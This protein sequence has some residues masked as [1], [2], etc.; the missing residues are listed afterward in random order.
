[1][2]EKVKCIPYVTNILHI[3]AVKI[4]FLS[5]W[6]QEAILPAETELEN[7]EWCV[8]CKEVLQQSSSEIL[9]ALEADTLWDT[10]HQPLAL[11]LCQQHDLPW[12][13]GSGSFPGLWV[14][15]L[16]CSSLFIFSYYSLNS[17]CS[18]RP[19]TPPCHLWLFVH[20]RYLLVCNKDIFR[21]SFF[22]DK[23][24]SV[25]TL[26]S[27]HKGAAVP[28]ITTSKKSGEVSSL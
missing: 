2:W 15:H 6:A 10:S 19:S 12:S 27:R 7:L 3:L 8:L 17:C 21:I 5:Q 25:Y 24:G 9:A 18:L 23:L 11:P 28:Q 22:H 14:Y 4:Y 20:Q 26:S 1:M 16:G 13:R